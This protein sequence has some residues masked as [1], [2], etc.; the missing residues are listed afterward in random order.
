MTP[1]RRL[2]RMFGYTVIEL[3]AVL[4]ILSTLAMMVLPMASMTQ[5]RTRE[6]E[7]RLALRDIRQAL[8]AYAKASADG[9]L[10]GTAGASAYPASLADLTK[11]WPDRRA[12]HQ[13]EL[14]RFLRKLPRN[15]F[16][17]ADLPADK[18]WGLRSY[19]SEA[20]KPQPGSDVYDVYADSERKALDGT[21]LRS[22]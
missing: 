7:L 1:G 6:T 8:D 11:A 20:D 17:A 10:T 4:A 18:S 21:L 5:Q 16:A 22:W 14:L 2:R 13:G 3:V 9:A 12:G 15:P 19:A